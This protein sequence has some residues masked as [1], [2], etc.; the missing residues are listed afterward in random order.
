M[1]G[2][3][4]I[5]AGMAVALAMA[6][7]ALVGAGPAAAD[8][9]ASVPVT[10][11]G[12]PVIGSISATVDINATDN[13]DPVAAGGTVVN[14]IKVPIPV[15]DPPVDVTIKEVKLTVAIPS[16]VTV[17]AVGFTSSSFTSQTWVVNGANLVVTLSGTVV[18]SKGK[19]APTVPDISVTT[20]VAGPAR[21]VT[22][23]VPSAISAKGTTILGAFTASCTADN[24]NTTL[25]TT[26]VT[27]SN[28]A[29][30]ATDQAVTVGYQTAKAITLAGTDPESNP[31]TFALGATAPSHGTLSGTPPNLTYTPAAGYSGPDSFTFTASDGSLSDLGTISITVGAAPSSV[32]ATDQAVAVSYQTAKAI[33]LEGVDPA[34]HPLTFALGATAPAHGALTGTPPNVTYTPAAGYVGPDSFTFTASNGT[35]SDDG[36]VTITV[37]AAVPG[38]PTITAKPSVKEGQATVRWSAPP[39]N[40]GSPITG[41]KVVPVANGVPQAPVTVAGGGTLVT[42]L[43]G[44]AN[45]VVHTFTVAAVNAVGTGPASASSLAV[46]PQWW[47][48]WTAGPVAVTQ[49]YTWFTGVA[50]SATNQASWLAQLNGGT[51]RLGDLVAALRTGTDATANVDPTARLY[52]A[53]FVRIPDASG[54][55]HW[56]TKKRGGTKIT[57]ISAEFAKS[58]EF[59]RRYGALSNQAFV[60][61]I[62]LNVQG[63]TG[64]ASGVAFWTKQLDAKKKTR[65]EVMVGFSESNEYKRTQVANLHAA[66]VAIAF[67]G[68]APGIDQRDAFVAALTGSNVAAVV[69]DL[70]HTDAVLANRVG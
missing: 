24:A 5:A 1:R 70:I 53:Y 69:R 44:L 27:A 18:I 23:K 46:T 4:T 45:G 6:G 59:T 51:K 68:R 38:A 9:I 12:I 37:A 3:R 22:W 36:T 61:Q 34:S 56:I 2:V 26:T 41:W 58:S 33:T 57:A 28:S 35:V 31:L 66:I 30:T 65:G 7:S 47:L 42:T 25:I 54:L 67:D 15:V 39:S 17:S 63:R 55:Q 48:P 16:G 40:G 14:T 32:T 20:T 43:T 19:P 13:V 50:P 52:S 60:K 62:Y 64:E 21:T 11:T 49:L 29:P 10:C 8:G